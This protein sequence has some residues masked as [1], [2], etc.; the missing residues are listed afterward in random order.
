MKNKE[1]DELFQISKSTEL[2]EQEIEELNQN[3][4]IVFLHLFPNFIDDF[5]ALLVPEAQIHPKEENRLTTDLRIFALIRLGIEDSSKIAEFLHYS[6]NTVY[7]YRARIKNGAVGNRE[8]FER[9]VKEL[10][11]PR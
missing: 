1:L 10:G 6:V 3:F 8:T 5:N 2:K 4:D 7:N 9:Q 11:M